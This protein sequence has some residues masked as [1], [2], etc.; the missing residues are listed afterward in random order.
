[1]KY[2]QHHPYMSYNINGKEYSFL[3]IFRKNTLS[4]DENFQEVYVLRTNDSLESISEKLYDT[5]DNSWLLFLNNNYFL[6]TDIPS[7]NTQIQLSNKKVYSIK[8][9]HNIKQNDIVIDANLDNFGVTSSFLYVDSWDPVFRSV[10][11]TE[12]GASGD[13]FQ[14]HQS[15]A[16]IRKNIDENGFDL[17]TPPGGISLEK[18]SY[19]ENF[20]I[21]FR[22]TTN[23]VSPYLNV[24]GSGQTYF[25]ESC[26]GVTFNKT[27]LNSYITDGISHGAY[28]IVTKANKYTSQK[29]EISIKTPIVDAVSPIESEIKKTMG[30]LNRSRLFNIIIQ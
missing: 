2:F 19:V 5:P 13:S 23:I 6:H 11:V 27:L 16:I 30:I 12:I 26:V 24:S 14:K 29:T 20:P 1:M 3:D 28:S 15:I 4:V 25:S 22:S 8:T 7:F 10:V 17:I 21:R 9:I 18:I